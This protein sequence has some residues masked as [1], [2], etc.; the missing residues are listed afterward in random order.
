MAEIGGQNP[1][2]PLYPVSRPKPP[3]RRERPRKPDDQTRQEKK[4]NPNHKD[5]DKP[6]IDEYA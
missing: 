1:L 5:D 2:N 6:H 3:M 4:K